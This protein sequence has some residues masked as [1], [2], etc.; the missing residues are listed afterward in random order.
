MDYIFR[1]VTYVFVYLDDILIASPDEKTHE[2][3][4]RNVLRILDEYK[5]TLNIAKCL[6]GKNSIQFLGYEVNTDGILPLEEK[7]KAIANFPK[8]KTVEQLRRF[9]GMVNFYR[10]SLSN[11]ATTQKPLNAYMHNAKK[12]QNTDQLDNK[13][14]RSLRR[15]KKVAD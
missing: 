10:K 15:N 4:I 1:N 12:G 9:L 13:S 7:S 3:H 2:E 14:Q 5:L 11:A 6:L 8:P